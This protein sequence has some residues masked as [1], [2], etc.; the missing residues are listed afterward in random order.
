MSLTIG[1]IG[2]GGFAYFATT[3]FLKID[4]V[5][6]HGIFDANQTNAA[7]FQKLDPSARIFSSLD[8]LCQEA[9]IDLVYIA[10]PP[11]LHYEQSKA[12]L[13]AGKHVICEKPAAT[14]LAHA[15]ELKELAER[16][17]LLFVVN[18]M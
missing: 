7:H 17:N 10:T 1:V 2:A 3:E 15:L 4:G 12:A 5:K 14:Q 6:L 13:L 16:K 11:F 18:L 8:D 9:S